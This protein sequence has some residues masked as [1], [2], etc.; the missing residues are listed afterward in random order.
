[1]SSATGYRGAVLRVLLTRRWLGALLLAALWSV[2]AYHLG[3][4][5]WHR[6]EAK[7]ARRDQ[8]EQHYTAA[9]VSLPGYLAGGAPLRAGDSWVRVRLAGTYAAE[10]LLVRN[11][12]REGASGYEVVV[13]LR[14]DDGATVLVDRGWAPISREGAARLPDV[15]PPPSGPVEVVGWL[16][17]GEPSLHRTPAPGSLASINLEEAGAALEAPLLGAYVLVDSERAAD[18]STPPRPLPLEPPDTSLGPNQAY[19]YQWWLSTV[20]GFVL[21][22]LGVRREVREADPDRPPRPRKVRIWD[23]EDA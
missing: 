6:H 4:W 5:Q 18:G 21:V 8:V 2:A 9:P 20:L 15:A 22:H 13:P 11:R 1:M 10:Q 23:E 12:P 19:A 3:W 17:A 16:R 14:L 7:V